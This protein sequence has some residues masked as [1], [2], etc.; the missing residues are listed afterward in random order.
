[1]NS[2]IGKQQNNSNIPL[3][4]EDD[5]QYF[6]NEQMFYKK[7]CLTIADSLDVCWPYV[8]LLGMYI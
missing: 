5:E 3:I 2:I 8:F 1:M 7:M 4:S 6:C